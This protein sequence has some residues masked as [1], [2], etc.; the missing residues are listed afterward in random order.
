MIE[1]DGASVEDR[2]VIED[3]WAE[4]AR[5]TSGATI[6]LG[7]IHRPVC[8]AARKAARRAEQSFGDEIRN[9]QREDAALP[10]RLHRPHD[11]HTE[12]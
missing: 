4:P 8:W 12:R 5:L 10:F 3:A 9:F 11:Q 1:R 2:G 7:L 6:V